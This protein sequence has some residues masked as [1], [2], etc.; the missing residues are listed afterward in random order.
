MKPI[1]MENMEVVFAGEPWLH[2]LMPCAKQA[3]PLLERNEKIVSWVRPKGG[4]VSQ[5]IP[6]IR[7]KDKYFTLSLRMQ[8]AIYRHMPLLLFLSF[9]FFL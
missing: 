5:Q 6:A 9:F 4:H 7:F 1:P 2:R 8:K 3:I